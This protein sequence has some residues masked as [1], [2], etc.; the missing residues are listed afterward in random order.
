M[1]FNV[2]QKREEGNKERSGYVKKGTD[3][4]RLG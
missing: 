1:M 3:R 4:K 2:K